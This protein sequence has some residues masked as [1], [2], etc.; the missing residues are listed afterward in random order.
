MTVTII[1]ECVKCGYS[2]YDESPVCSVCGSPGY[3]VKDG[4]A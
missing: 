1:Y 4:E 2:R 3:L